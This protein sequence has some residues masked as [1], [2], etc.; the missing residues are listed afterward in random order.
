MS[1]NPMVRALA[2]VEG[3]YTRLLRH[4]GDTAEGADWT[5][6]ETRERRFTI[7]SQVGLPKD[8]KLLDF[9]C[10]TGELL[11]FLRRELDY[12]GEYVGWD[13]SYPVLNAAR[14]KYPN[15]RFERRE[16]LSD[17]VLEDFDY[18]L[19]SGTFNIDY[20][21]AE[22]F[23]HQALPLLFRHTRHALAFNLLS[24]C[25]QTHKPGLYYA[26]PEAI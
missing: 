11:G 7:L 9:G 2:R 17:G 14:L 8:E 6:R 22:Q 13:L 19:A 26:E 1:H 5:S 21:H 25:A 16:I 4:Y 15:A 10:G 20:G 24:T 12:R 18:I 3:H 23:L